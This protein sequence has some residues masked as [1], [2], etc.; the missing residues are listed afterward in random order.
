MP[1]IDS[2][3]LNEVY[4]GLEHT[5][6]TPAGT[7]IE[8]CIG[9]VV[10]RNYNGCGSDKIDL[11][12]YGDDSRTFYAGTATFLPYRHPEGTYVT[13]TLEQAE[14]FAAKHK[15]KYKLGVGVRAYISSKKIAGSFC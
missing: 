1:S 8:T 15:D 3:P 6:N 13:D 14:K 7:F 2:R 5:Y 11:N 12:S 4:K 9:F 10:Y